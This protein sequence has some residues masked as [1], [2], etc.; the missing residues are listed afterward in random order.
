MT[1][2]REVM[3]R[4]SLGDAVTG[5]SGF[6]RRE[7]I[8]TVAS[9]LS[10]EPMVATALFSFG[11]YVV[12]SAALIDLIAKSPSSIPRQLV[13]GAVMLAVLLR[14]SWD[15]GRSDSAVM[16]CGVIAALSARQARWF[17][18]AVALTVALAIHETGAIVLVPLVA[19]V[20]Y[21]HGTWRELPG[22]PLAIIGAMLAA[23]AALYVVSFRPIGDVQQVARHVHTLFLNPTYPD[24][25]LYFTLAGSRGLRTA[26]CEIKADPS[27]PLQI[28]A[29][30]A[31]LAILVC[32]LFQRR[33]AWL[34][35]L[36]LVW[37]IPL[38]LVATDVGRWAVFAAFSLFT[39]ALLEPAPADDA[40]CRSAG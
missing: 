16:I 2:C 39:V 40:P 6:A 36:S 14:L 5:E 12:L 33:Q 13:L 34:L 19:A 35:A 32:G 28:L 37:L 7:L 3:P 26:M 9:F 8:G 30:V 1:D 23:D 31:L 10:P 15:V 21:R 11:C 38:S 20:A 4:A 18:V 24:L 25:S 22:R 17:L 29:A 27:Y